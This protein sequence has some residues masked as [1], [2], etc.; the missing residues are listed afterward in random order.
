MVWIPRWGRVRWYR[1]RGRRRGDDV[2]AEPADDRLYVVAAQIDHFGGRRR[3]IVVD[4]PGHGGS[5]E[6]TRRSI[7]PIARADRGGP[8][9][10]SEIERIH[11]VGNSW[12]GMI[13]ATFAATYPDRTAAPCS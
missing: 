10:R 8:R 13:G 11:F 5:E 4:P 2:L 9:R 3:V 12:G 6:L 7:S 1:T